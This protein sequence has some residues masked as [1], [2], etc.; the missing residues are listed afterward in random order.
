MGRLLKPLMLFMAVVNLLVGMFSGLGRL[1]WVVPLPEA[2]AHHGAI[3]VGGFLG[4]LIALEKV[5]PLKQPW[6]Y[7]GPLLSASSVVVLIAGDFHLAV[8]MQVLAG[9]SFVLVYAAY[10]RQ[11]K[12]LPLWLAGAGA[13]AWVVASVL[14]L[15]KQFYPMVFPWYIAFLLFT[16]VSERL[17]LTRFLPVTEKNR[18][19]L[20]LLLALYLAG[21]AIPF[22]SWGKYMS[23]L[24]LVGISVWLLRF[25][26]IRI[27]LRKKE[28]VRFTAVALLCGYITLMLDGFFLLALGDQPFAYDML[29]HTFFLG[30]VFCMIFAH[31]PIILPGVLGLSVKPYSPFFYVPLA[32]LMASLMV[33]LLAGAMLLPVDYRATSGWFSM[34]AILLYFLSMAVTLIRAVK[35]APHQA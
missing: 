9:L 35:N 3:M 17:E 16:I 33:R 4:T 5:I 22:H 7:A 18:R 1:G 15:W 21:L 31:G 32:L 6:F 26:V 30:F 20:L 12:S 34:G 28:L 19:T 10:L 29:L 23:G 8:A 24:A 2:Y 13:L 11:Q 25:D 27:T 14:L